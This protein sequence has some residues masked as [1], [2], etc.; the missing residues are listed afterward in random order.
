M[1]TDKIFQNFNVNDNNHH[2]ST[3][4]RQ[5][6]E[7]QGCRPQNHCS[8]SWRWTENVQQAAVYP[9][10]FEKTMPEVIENNYCNERAIL[11]HVNKCHWNNS[12]FSVYGKK[13]WRNI[14]LVLKRKL[15]RQLVCQR[16]RRSDWP[17]KTRSLL[18][19]TYLEIADLEATLTLSWAQRSVPPLVIWIYLHSPH[20]SE[21]LVEGVQRNIKL[22][23]CVN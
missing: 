9:E 11:I 22:K 12:K 8:I 16:C 10:L 13:K 1:A 20:H 23:I 6:S 7:L 18:Q 4:Y 21:I 19:S 5:V 17:N 2:R 3:L 14:S 15:R